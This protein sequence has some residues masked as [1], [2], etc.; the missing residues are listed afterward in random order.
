MK[1]IIK[2]LAIHIDPSLKP[3]EEK[4]QPKGIIGTAVNAVSS[5]LGFGKKKEDEKKEE[6]KK[7]DK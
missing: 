7:D 6:V 1:D 2:Q 4:E 3:K 5:V